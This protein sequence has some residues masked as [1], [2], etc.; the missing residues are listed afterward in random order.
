MSRV[1]VDD[2]PLQRI[3]LTSDF[4]AIDLDVDPET[5][6]IRS[7]LLAITGGPFVRPGVTMVYRHTFEYDTH[8]E[9]PDAAA[10]VFDPGQRQKVDMLAALVQRRPA[11]AGPGPRGDGGG[12]LVGK[13]APALV[14]ATA[15]GKAVDLE[16]LRGHVVVLDFW[17]TWCGP[18][19]R[20]LPLL[21][22]VAQWAKAEELPVTVVTVNVW[23]I[24]D[25]DRDTPDAR[26]AS[27]RRFWREQGFTL[28]VAMD[29][30]DQTGAAYG[31]RGIPTTFVIRADG[32][33]H[34]QHAGVPPGYAETLK[35]EINEAIASLEAED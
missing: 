22:E 12:D 15:D 7:C 24:R 3:K 17:A 21:H 28:P 34:A 18:C 4:E 10:F 14:L 13:P 29:Y 31:V 30:S 11:P 26:L 6:L 9:P 35:A 23:E 1:V 27:A 20:A 25:P 19:R 33:V 32:I 8:E 2:K 16:A 5:K